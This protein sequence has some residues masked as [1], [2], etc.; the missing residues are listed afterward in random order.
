MLLYQVIGSP[1]I[2]DVLEVVYKAGK[3]QTD[4]FLQQPLAYTLGLS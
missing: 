2:I 3:P 4:I 1:G